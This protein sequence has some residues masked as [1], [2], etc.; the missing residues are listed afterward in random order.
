MIRGLDH[1]VLTVR[2]LDATR[3]FYVDGL[4]FEPRTFGDG[5]HALHV[6]EIKI[7]LH[8]AGREFEPSAEHPTPGSGDLCFLTDR[9]LDVVAAR[10]AALG[11]RVIEGPVVR[12][13]AGGP[14]TSIYFRDPAGNLIEVGRP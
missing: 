8:L 10:M 14:I 1:L 13:G 12:T 5:R 11:H 4:G 6:G 7:N 9:P 2:D 3:R